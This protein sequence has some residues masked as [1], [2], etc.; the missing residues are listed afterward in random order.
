VLE[1]PDGAKALGWPGF[2]RS[3]VH[4]SPLM[5]DI[6]MD[7]IRDVVVTTFDGEVVFFK[8]NVSTAEGRCGQPCMSLCSN[9][10]PAC[11]RLYHVA[12]QGAGAGQAHGSRGSGRQWQRSCYAQHMLQASTDSLSGR[13]CHLGHPLCARCG[14]DSCCLMY[15][16]CCTVSC[17]ESNSWSVCTSRACGCARIGMWA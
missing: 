17:R 6:D 13:S 12:A 16:F 5:F 11:I 9:R 14:R 7:G 1:G 10:R 3:H 4:T 15:A 2:H 8:D